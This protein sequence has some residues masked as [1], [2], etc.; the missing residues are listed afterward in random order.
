MIG[1]ELRRVDAREKALGQ[2]VYTGDLS[3]SHLLWARVLRSP[4][5]H[6]RIVSVD[7]SGAEALGAIC[8]T[9]KDVPDITYNERMVSIPEKTY[10]D[11]K[12]L[13]DTVRH[14][15]EGVSAVAARTTALAR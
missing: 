3:F 2:A 14:V 9:H 7:V 4:Y 13:S 5:P 15:G 12:V 8:I 6:A 11:R 1:A 10:R